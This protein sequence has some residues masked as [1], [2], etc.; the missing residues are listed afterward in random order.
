[1]SHDRPLM[2]ININYFQTS[3]V[4]TIFTLRLSGKQKHGLV[5]RKTLFSD[6]FTS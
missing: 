1:M 3:S 2:T 5:V 4:T 6:T